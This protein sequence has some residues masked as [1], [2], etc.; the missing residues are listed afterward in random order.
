MA[1]NES[2]DKP[3]RLLEIDKLQQ[4]LIDLDMELYLLNSKKRLILHRISD[5]QYDIKTKNE[6]K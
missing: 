6:T 3:S 2:D 4:E 1:Y 5:L